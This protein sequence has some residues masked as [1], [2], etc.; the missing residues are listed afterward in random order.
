MRRALSVG[1]RDQGADAGWLALPVASVFTHQEALRPS[2][3]QLQA[4]RDL[5]SLRIPWSP[6]R[7][8]GSEARQIGILFKI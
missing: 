8:V 4:Q 6:G 5:P 7:F 1:P 3:A 2:L